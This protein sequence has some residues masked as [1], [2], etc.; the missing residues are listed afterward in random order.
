MLCIDYRI[1][2]VVCVS[3]KSSKSLWTVDKKIYHFAYVK[4]L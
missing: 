3:L 2:L 1:L 4:T